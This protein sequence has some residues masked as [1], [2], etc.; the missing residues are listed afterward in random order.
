M[1][2][3]ATAGHVDHGKSPLV[4][5][6][7]GVDPDRL[8]EEQA[9][10]LTIDLG[11][12]A[13]HLPSGALI[14][15]VDVPG[16]VRFLNN[17]LAGVGSVAAAMF[18][19]SAAEGW[20]PQSEEHLRILE[21]VG[22]R[23]GIVVV[24]NVDRVD[25]ERLATVH[26]EI[27]ERVAGTFLA[28]ATVVGVSVPHEL[29]LHDLRAGLEAVAVDHAA[30]SATVI[31]QRPRPRL[32]IDRSF[33]ARGAGTIV[34]GTLSGGALAVG[35]TVEVSGPTAGELTARI[36]GL[37]MH[38]EAF[39]RIDPG[40]RCAVN[41]AGVHHGALARGDAVLAAGRWHR[42]D[43]FD[44]S[45]EVL[46][47]LG[48]RVGRRGAYSVHIGASVLSATMT[49]LGGRDIG[50]GGTGAVR[51]RLPSMLPLVAGDRFVLREAG[52]SET[53]GGGVVLD[54]SPVLPA[55]RARP[56]DSVERIV[57]EH[58][59]I[60]TDLL[61]RLTGVPAHTPGLPEVGRWTVDA[62]ALAEAQ[63]SL[64]RT[65][66]LGGPS[67]VSIAE[68]TNR[69]R[70]VLDTLV[71]V[72][73]SG[74]LVR[75]AQS[76]AEA[77]HP[78]VTELRSTPFAPTDPP[79]SLDAATLRRLRSDGLIVRLEGIWFATTAVTAATE[80]IGGLL[81][82]RPDGFTVSEARDRLRTS[83]KFTMALLGHLDDLAVTRRRGDLR[84]A[85]PRRS[86]TAPPAGG[87]DSDELG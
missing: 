48:H 15:F 49:V 82:D 77:L 59:W 79:S 65:L 86:V 83:R 14:E 67:G 22:I 9:R 50:P 34:T 60:D 31:L 70:A 43:Q 80:V 6:L 24:T 53:I 10:G 69:E 26:S 37:Q 39:D 38:G 8:A 11:F 27:A 4:R 23:R 57:A 58:G 74:G 13:F 62:V 52:R 73:S 71:G 61:E 7:T 87:T 76:A 25:A 35:D 33:A 29:G 12:A 30:S 51:L 28:N 41:L 72:E 75:W 3:V 40:H 17:M 19:V 84:V 18:V 47:S 66:D 44:A 16:H 21:L 63:R 81:E 46:G 32:W 20:K 54:V 42:T 78:F 68:L 56:D 36:R 45:L 2:V 1:T 64:G 85:G 5:A 55:S